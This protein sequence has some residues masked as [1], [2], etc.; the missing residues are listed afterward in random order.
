MTNLLTDDSAEYLTPVD[1][2]SRWKNQV[3][4]RTLANWRVQGLGPE[5]VKIGNR[6][7]YALRSVIAWEQSRQMK[8]TAKRGP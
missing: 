4:T 1:L 8:Q 2:V 5:F 3:S 7:L 6:V